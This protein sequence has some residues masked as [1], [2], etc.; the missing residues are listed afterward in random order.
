MLKIGL[1]GPLPPPYGGM[2]NQLK[3]LSQLLTDEGVQVELLQNNPPYPNRYIANLKGVRAVFRLLYFVFQIW[4]LCHRVD[5]IHVFS[6]S[7][8]SWQLFSAPVLLIANLKKTPVIINYRGGEADTYFAQN[9]ER[10]RP[11][12]KLASSIIVPSGFLQAVFNKYGFSDAEIIPNIIN[13]ERFKITSHK[14]NFHLIITRNLETIYGIETAIKSLSTVKRNYPNIKLTIAGSGDQK[15]NLEALVKALEL[16]NH[17]VFTGRLTPEQIAQLYQE[18]DIMLNPTT[19]DNMPNSV[20]EALACGLPVVTTN[21]GGIPYIIKDYETALFVDVN[22][23]EQM[24][25]KIIEL[26][27]NPSLRNQLKDNGIQEVQ[28]YTWQKIKPQWMGLYKSLS[29]N[30]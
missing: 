7:G 4:K 22:D 14:F 29:D 27:E 17:V 10:V 30:K 1:V 23:H 20:L 21:V 19:V 8:W 13:T 16:N 15:S 25:K 9:I 11:T 18:A 12:L 2:A 28:K 24:A 6:N 5:V 3:Q 26:I